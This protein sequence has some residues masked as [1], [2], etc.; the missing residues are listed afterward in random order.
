MVIIGELMTGLD[1]VKGEQNK[2]IIHK[3]L[4]E[5]VRTHKRRIRPFRHES[6]SIWLCYYCPEMVKLLL[7]L[8]RSP[9]LIASKYCSLFADLLHR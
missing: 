1:R 4:V 5:F 3:E 9:E 8:R 7:G 6:K 2:K